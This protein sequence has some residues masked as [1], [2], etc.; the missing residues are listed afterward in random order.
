MPDIYKLKPEIHQNFQLA[1]PLIISNSAQI[2]MTLINT[3]MMGHLGFEFLAAGGLAAIISITCFLSC[4][5]LNQGV[6]VYIAQAYPSR[7]F[8]K[9]RKLVSNGI[10]LSSVQ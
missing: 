3:I 1:V 7:N 6:T 8:K 9:M 5:G 2:I 4:I 10:Y